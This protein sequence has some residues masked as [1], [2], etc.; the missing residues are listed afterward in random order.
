MASRLS[1]FLAELRRR[2]VGRVAVVYVLVGVGVV[3]AADLFLTRLPVPAWVA[4]AIA[5]VV[6]LGFPIALVLAWAIDVTPQGIQRTQALTPEQRISKET[7]RWAP[8]VLSLGAAV[9]AVVIVAGYLIY[10]R[11]G[12]DD[13]DLEENRVFVALFENQT[14]DPALD[15]AGRM[16]ADFIIRDLVNTGVV[17]VL[18][19]E[20]AV[21]VANQASEGTAQGASLQDQAREMGAAFMVSGSFF[22][23]GDSLVVQGQL[24]D[25]ARG[26]VRATLGPITSS[27][28][29]PS[30]GFT[31]LAQRVSGTI[32]AAVDPTW[33]PHFSDMTPVTSYAAYAEMAAG[34]DAFMHLDWVEA[35]ERMTRAFALDTTNLAALLN[36]IVA[37]R[38]RGMQREADSV[39]HIAERLRGRANPIERANLD[40]YRAWFDGDREAAFRVME[41]A[42]VLRPGG[43]MSFQLGYEAVRTNRLRRA[44]EVLEG[45]DPTRPDVASWVSYWSRLTSA[46]HM[47]G[48]YDKELAAA[49]RGQAQI[50]ASVVPVIQEV[51]AL[52]GLG[53]VQE[54]LAV[55]D[56]YRARGGGIGTVRSM[57]LEYRAHGHPEAARDVLNSILEWHDAQAA[58][59]D[60]QRGLRRSR[61]ITL[62]LLERW[63][64]AR[65]IFAE[66]L[67][68]DP[69]NDETL[70]YVGS[71][72]AR[73]GEAEDAVRLSRELENLD[74]PYLWGSNT[75]ERA[76]IAALLGDRD[77]AVRLHAQA[78]REGLQ[79]S[80]DLHR[81]VDLESLRGFAPYEEF[82]RP[83][84]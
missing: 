81:D 22:G 25:V 40:L 2:K 31:D 61:A 80:V 43:A 77:G 24:L 58:D 66:L 5:I 45:M 52:I 78:H 82:M 63:E 53:R 75:R 49:L 46:H 3:E 11:G 55:L 41:R 73:T 79:Y 47:L 21:A 23:Q 35:I 83:R 62:Y 38:N 56:E 54:S 72:M 71:I 27:K 59:P 50:P 1:V 9:L 57:A 65:V 36:I 30:R 48:E 74:Q 51:R 13:Q 42:E 84:Q 6:L 64:E 7:E 29:E 28:A 67:A 19:I 20:A 39:R 33:S 44:V 69:Q 10:F 14:G 70:G 18:P 8:G 32:A 68:E 34:Y 26:R 15:P 16:A 17:E 37:Y 4:D 60:T 76:R 12:S